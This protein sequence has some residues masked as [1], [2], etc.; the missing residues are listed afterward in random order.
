[1]DGAGIPLSLWVS[2]ANVHDVIGLEATLAARI[3]VCP[4]P[5]Q[6][7]HLCADM[8]YTGH[9]ALETMIAYGFIPHVRSRKDE[10]VHHPGGKARR[11]VVEACHSWFNRFRK[12]LVRFEKTVASYYALCCFAAAVI[13]WNKII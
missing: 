5:A 3:I 2:A 9:K 1:V 11:W 10:A 8:G 4:D 13:I 12:L 7:Q 6:E